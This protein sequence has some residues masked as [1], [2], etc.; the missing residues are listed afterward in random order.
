METDQNNRL[1]MEIFR[2]DA[3]KTQTLTLFERD[4]PLDWME[5]AICIFKK[6]I[7]Q[8]VTE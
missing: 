5:E 6:E 4:I 8:S 1:M 2:D 3:G 7:P